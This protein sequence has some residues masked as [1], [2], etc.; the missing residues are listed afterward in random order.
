MG[1]DISSS[2]IVAAVTTANPSGAASVIS[3]SFGHPLSIVLTVKLDE[4]N[5]L[6]WRG[7][8]LAI[9]KGQ[10]VDEYVLGTKAQPS[11]F[12]ETIIGTE[13]KLD[14]NPLYEEWMT[15]DQALSCWFFGSMS[16]AIAVDVV[17]FKTSRE[18]WKAL[19]EV[20]GATSKARVNQLR[21]I[22]QNT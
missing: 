20:Y 17:N 10:K 2:S 3:S 18:V 19:E 6:L 8:I 1:D 21:G 4:K 9:L 11:D 14:P 12:I 16:P 15:V 7:M 13:K 5:Y 22:L